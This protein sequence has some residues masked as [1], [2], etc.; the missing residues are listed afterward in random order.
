MSYKTII[1][2][3]IRLP[4]GNNITTEEPSCTAAI[5]E[6]GKFLKGEQLKF[7]FEI[8]DNVSEGIVTSITIKSSKEAKTKKQLN[9]IFNSSIRRYFYN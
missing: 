6:I 4:N 5:G 9:N 7:E 3:K 1:A 8:D 2:F